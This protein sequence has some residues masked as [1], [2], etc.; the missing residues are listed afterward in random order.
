[1][2]LETKT[3]KPTPVEDLSTQ[4]ALLVRYMQERGPISNLIAI[5]NLGVGSLSKRMAELSRLGWPVLKR[6][7]KDFGGKDYVEYFLRRDDPAPKNND[8]DD[9]GA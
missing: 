7:K 2:S 5:T 4:N 8:A 9:D 3:T 6:R 1:M